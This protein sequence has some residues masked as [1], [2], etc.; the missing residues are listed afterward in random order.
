MREKKILEQKFTQNKHFE[1]ITKYT[2]IMNQRKYLPIL[3][4]FWLLFANLL[5]CTRELNCHR[6]L[7]RLVSVQNSIAIEMNVRINIKSRKISNYLKLD[8]NYRTK[9]KWWTVMSFFVSFFPNSIGSSICCLH[10]THTVDGS[11]SNDS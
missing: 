3:M 9:Q 7:H 5:N 10:K 11:S 2:D 6:R 1:C 4:L 8:E